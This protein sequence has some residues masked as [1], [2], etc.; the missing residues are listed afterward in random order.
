LDAR[1]DLQVLLAKI[2]DQ[3]AA[4]KSQSFAHRW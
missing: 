2:Y 1:R 3:R 4:F